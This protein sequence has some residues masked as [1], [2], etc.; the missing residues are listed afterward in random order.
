MR[1]KMWCFSFSISF[2]FLNLASVVYVWSV[3][4]ITVRLSSLRR[5]PSLPC[6]SDL[7]LK[8]S[9]SSWNFN[10]WIFGYWLIPCWADTS[11]HPAPY[12]S[13]PIWTDLKNGKLNVNVRFHKCATGDTQFTVYSCYGKVY[14]KKT[15]QNKKLKGTRQTQKIIWVVVINMDIKK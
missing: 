10:S 6:F 8:V 9:V 2:L 14:R 3:S 5:P 13:S 4:I 12:S 11:P 7:Q 1:K 15:K